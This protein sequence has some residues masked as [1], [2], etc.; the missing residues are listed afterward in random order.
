MKDSLKNESMHETLSI[1]DA[2]IVMKLS[3]SN[4]VR[5]LQTRIDFL[6]III[7]ENY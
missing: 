2:G 7:D 1:L 5:S 3:G 6:S 4:K